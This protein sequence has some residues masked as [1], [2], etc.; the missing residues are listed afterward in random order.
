MAALRVTA[1]EIRDRVKA[2]STLLVC[3]YGDDKKFD[4]YHLDGA[5]AYSDF[6][7]RVATLPTDTE[8]V[9]YCA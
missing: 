2:G 7:K 8:I 9:F 4:S 3:A 1:A 6:K 5:I